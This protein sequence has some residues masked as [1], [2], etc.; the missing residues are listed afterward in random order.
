MFGIGKKKHPGQSVG[1]PHCS[2]CRKSQ[3]D[4]RTL[5]AGPG[6]MICDECVGICNDIVVES[7]KDSAGPMAGTVL[8]CGLCRMPAAL[9][10]SLAIPDRGIVCAGCAAAIEAALAQRNEGS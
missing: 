2:F 4:V 9:D 6:V 3:R 8:V 5:I 7:A 1:L 10:E